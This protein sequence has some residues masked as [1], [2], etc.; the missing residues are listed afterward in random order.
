M[1]LIPRTDLDVFPLCLGGNVFG[2]TADEQQSFAVLDAYTDAGGNFIDTAEGYSHWVP[3]NVGGESETIIGNWLARRGRRDDVVIATKLKGLTRDSIRQNVEASLRRLQTDHID[4]YYAHYDDPA[5]PQE[6][7]VAALGELVTEGKVR[8]LAASNFTADRLKSSLR[9][10]DDLGVARYVALQPHYNLLERD[11]VEG[12]LAALV[13][14]EDLAVFPYYSL[15]SGFL[16]G[17]YRTVDDVVGRERGDRA[18][19]YLDERGFRVLDALDRVA[20]AHGA[21]LT[22][23]ALAWLLSRPNVLAPIA[24]ARTVEQLPALMQQ[25]E[26]TEAEVDELTTASA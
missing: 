2:W 26:L 20:A 3:G 23:I 21:Q 4:L 19:N 24:S 15:A 17:K 8:Y 13:A 25:V 14:G 11:I 22:T 1:S 5:A 6:E 18:G 10:A 7:T 16:T 12:E 9:I